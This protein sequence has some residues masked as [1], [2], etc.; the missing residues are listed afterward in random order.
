MKRIA[1]TVSVVGL[2]FGVAILA[3]TQTESVELELIRLDVY[4]GRKRPVIPV[5]SGHLFWFKAAT[6]SG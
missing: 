1:I 5:Q 6:D 4:S 2:V 3:Q